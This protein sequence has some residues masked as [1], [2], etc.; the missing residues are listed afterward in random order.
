MVSKEG[1]PDVTHGDEDAYWA[2][3]AELGQPAEVDAHTRSVLD[4]YYTARQLTGT[5]VVAH[6]M[7]RSE[8]ESGDLRQA[9]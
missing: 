9:A 3:G 4:A 1:T 7:Q 6:F 2:I 5:A 8:A